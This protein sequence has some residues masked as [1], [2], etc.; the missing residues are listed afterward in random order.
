V[1]STALSPNDKRYHVAVFGGMVYRCGP[2]P[3]LDVVAW[4]GKKNSGMIT[5][6]GIIG[7][8]WL[9]TD[10]DLIDFSVGSWQHESS[11]EGSNEVDAAMFGMQGAPL[12]VWTAPP[13]PDFFWDNKRQWTAPWNDHGTPALG[14]AWY[15][16]QCFGTPPPLPPLEPIASTCVRNNLEA[17]NIKQR[18]R[19]IP[20]SG[21]AREPD[22]ER[23]I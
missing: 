12:P 6:M 17:R 5:P 10:I 21:P 14:I 4:C 19:A 11:L 16:H 2:S 1:L 20:Q 7:H 13:L 23:K 15:G 22:Y 18:L 3:R 9:E 8:M